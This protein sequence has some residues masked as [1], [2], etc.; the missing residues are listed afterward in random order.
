MA[1]R[2]PTQKTY[3]SAITLIRERGRFIGFVEATA[4][5]AS[6]KEAIKIFGSKNLEQQRRPVGRR[7]GRYFLRQSCSGALTPLSAVPHAGPAPKEV[8]QLLRR[9]Q[10]PAHKGSSP[11]TGAQCWRIRANSRSSL[12]TA[13]NSGI[14]GHSRHEMGAFP[15]ALRISQK[16]LRVK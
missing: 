7:E 15:R 13:I 1:A 14:S 10:K 12:G 11:I 5:K 9:G 3:T 4:E 16:R 8:S 2:K 6:I